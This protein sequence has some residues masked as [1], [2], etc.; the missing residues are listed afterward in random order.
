MVYSS[1]DPSIELGQFHKVKAGL[2]LNVESSKKVNREEAQKTEE[3]V[4]VWAY[5]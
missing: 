3:H 5:H 4:N 2:R 1:N